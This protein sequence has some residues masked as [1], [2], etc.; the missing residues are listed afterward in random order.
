MSASQVKELRERTGLGVLECKKALAAAGGDVD[1]AIEELRKSSGMKAAKKAGRTAADGVVAARVAD[2]GS[3]GV[4]VEVNSETD[5]VARDAGFLQF[6]QQVLQAV[7]EARSDDV[8]SLMDGELESARQALVQ[9]IGENIGVRRAAVVSAGAG[10]VG[11]YVHGNKR[12]AVL[13]ELEA[14]DQDL[15]RD[16]AM[17]VAAVNP[18]VVRPDD[19]PGE[20][21]EKEKEIYTAQALES[22]KPPEIVEKMIGGRIRKFLSE[23]SLVEQ[24]FVKDPE[25]SVGKLVAAAGASVAS[26]ARFE[27]GEGIEVEQVDFAS[28]VAAQLRG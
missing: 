18:Q 16:V 7:F 25:L 15:A 10:V 23:N 19:M 3:Y 20:L 5:F 4:L 14:G 17:H 21:L 6:V 1:A 11:A 13:V 2:D 24:P 22:G 9:K 26:F 27:V 12:I 28:E 8:A